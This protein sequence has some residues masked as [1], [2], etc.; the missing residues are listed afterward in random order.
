MI[1]TH[2]LP[3][4][5]L[6]YYTNDIR[7]TVVN[8]T[9]EG[10][11][12]ATVKLTDETTDDVMDNATTVAD[13]KF[14]FVGLNPAH[15]YEVSITTSDMSGVKIN[16]LNFDKSKAEAQV[17]LA[18]G[19]FDQKIAGKENDIEIVFTVK[20]KIETAVDNVEAGKAVASVRY[21]NMQGVE[22]ATPFAGVNVAVT[23][24]A[25]GSKTTTKV[26]K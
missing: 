18:D 14:E 17:K 12:G 19:K 5:G 10:I 25:D 26:V 9:G 7:G 20:P 24:Y 21:I 1:Q 23:T 15:T 4:F 22:S 16:R 6:K 3:A 13:G 8:E 2:R 11:A